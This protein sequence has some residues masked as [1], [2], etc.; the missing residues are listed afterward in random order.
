MDHLDYIR[1]RGLEDSD[2]EVFQGIGGNVSDSTGGG[3]SGSAPAA[4]EWLGIPEDAVTMLLKYTTDLNTWLQS[5]ADY[6]PDTRG[7]ML[8]LA[9]YVPEIVSTVAAGGA[10]VATGG[11]AVPAVGTILAT[12]ALLNFVGARV[13]EYAKSLDPNS[14]Q[15]LI[16]KAFLYQDASDDLKSILGKALLYLNPSDQTTHESVLDTALNYDDT[17][18]GQTAHR[19]AVKDGLNDLA[20]VDATL[21]MDNDLKVRVKGKALEF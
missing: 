3:S 1:I 11:A 18:E 20:M 8:E 10:I 9:P 7:D 13:S 19:S 16:K 5:A 6:T 21:T 17:F 4:P 15:N 2:T 14:P 12:Q